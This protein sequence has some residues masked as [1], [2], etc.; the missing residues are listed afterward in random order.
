MDHCEQCRS[1]YSAT[2][3]WQR[4]CSLRC[5]NAWHRKL[6]REDQIEDARR[7]YLVP[8]QDVLALAGVSA[9]PAE[10]KRRF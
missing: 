8:S 10:F 1:K 5:R 3:P 4:F 9:V 7:G 2:K 6:R